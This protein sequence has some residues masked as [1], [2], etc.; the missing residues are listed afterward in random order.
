MLMPEGEGGDGGKP[1]N[2]VVLYKFPVGRL[3][4]MERER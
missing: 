3:L 1:I 4:E 2:A